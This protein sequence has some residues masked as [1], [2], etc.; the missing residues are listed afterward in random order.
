[1]SRTEPDG[2]SGTFADELTLERA[3]RLALSLARV[4]LADGSARR[5]VLVGFDARFLSERL[6]LGS[7]AA[8]AEAGVPVLL[9]K[10][11][12]PLPAV[13]WAVARGRRAAGMTWGGG[14]RPPEEGRLRI[15]V[16]GGAPASEAFVT[17]LLSSA[18]AGPEAPKPGARKRR[19]A[20]RLFDPKAGYLAAL[21]RRA[22]GRGTRKTRLRVGCDPR[23]GAAAGWL[24]EA[25][26]STGFRV[27]ALHDTPAPE[28]G[29]L[30]PACGERELGGL[31]RLVRR[32]KLSLGLGVDGEGEHFGIV[33]ARGAVVPAGSILALLAD[34]LFETGRLRAGVSRSRATTHLLDDVASEHGRPLFETAPGFRNVL[35]P[36]LRGEAGL[37]CEEGGS[38]ALASHLP[39]ADGLLAVL[40]A[41]AMT[42]ARRRPLGEQLIALFRRI[43]P[44]CGRRIDYHVDA[45]TRDRVLRRLEE[46]PARFAGRSIQRLTV[47][48]GDNKWIFAD[49]AWVLF[50]AAHDEPAL[51]CHL[52][53]RSPRDLESLTH[54]VRDLVS[55]E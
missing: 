40:L 12:L 6:A 13:G 36:V 29:G 54:A 10:T 20:V 52:E 15:H 34:F 49:G 51:R 19:G 16:A 41:A 1:M 3:R 26:R 38:L 22:A 17:R 28:F 7:A 32:G 11:P 4:L 8:L 44:R 35:Q 55:A 48:D 14:D 5:G 27:E 50:R 46:P 45:A 42:A 43:G 25:C 33:D 31:A 47:A 39:G 9:A 30:L 2:L 24:S 37:A 53:A 21:V 18:E 23:H